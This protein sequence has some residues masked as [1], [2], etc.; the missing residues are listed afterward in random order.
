MQS[1]DHSL[2]I[3][4]FCNLPI[5]P[6]QETAELNGQLMHFDCYREKTGS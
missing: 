6:G 1:E 3:C 2:P 4:P 5:E